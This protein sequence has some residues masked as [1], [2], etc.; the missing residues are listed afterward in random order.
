M[1]GLAAGVGFVCVGEAA[2]VQPP[3]VCV[4]EAASVQPPKSSSPVTVG[5]CLLFADEVIGAPHAPEMSFGVIRDGTEPRDT[6]GGFG[7]GGSGSGAA[8][9]LLS[10]PP[11]GLPNEELDCGGKAGC[12]IG[13]TIVGFDATGDDRLKGELRFGG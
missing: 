4:G 5:V 11:Q 3:L 6:V 13:A 2:D 9:A 12:G 1:D 7:F 10:M 8:H